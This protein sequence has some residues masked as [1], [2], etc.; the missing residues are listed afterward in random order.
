MQ[1][2][3][4]EA[5]VGDGVPVSIYVNYPG[6]RKS[7]DR[8]GASS[9]KV[10]KLASSRAKRCW[11]LGIKAV[12]NYAITRCYLKIKTVFFASMRLTDSHIAL[13]CNLSFL[14]RL[15]FPFAFPFLSFSFLFSSSLFSI[16]LVLFSTL[17]NFQVANPS[18]SIAKDARLLFADSSC[19][20]LL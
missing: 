20:F 19:F 14:S 13:P 3:G 12:I 7:H 15:F 11:P 9:G 17:V 1:A 4:G 10:G 8:P 5:K 16:F 2:R 6:E 18:D